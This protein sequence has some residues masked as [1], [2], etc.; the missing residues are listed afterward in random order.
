MTFHPNLGC[1]RESVSKLSVL[2]VLRSRPGILRT[3]VVRETAEFV[4]GVFLASRRERSERFV[5][6]KTLR[7]HIT[8]IG[9]TLNGVIGRCSDRFA[10]IRSDSVVMPIGVTSNGV[11][12]NE[13]VFENSIWT[14][15]PG[16]LG[17]SRSLHRMR[18]VFK[19]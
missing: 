13:K 1:P 6:K 9:V 16:S 5:G 19:A 10:P 12:L 18:A 7:C 4:G 11:T 2:R 15:G 8:L 3:L 14:S 17:D